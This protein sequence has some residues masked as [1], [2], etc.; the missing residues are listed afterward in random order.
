MGDTSAMP[1][2]LSLAQARAVLGLDR[3]D[4]PS[5]AAA[6]RAAAKASHPDRAGGDVERFRR[7]VEA[8]TVVRAADPGALRPVRPAP[9]PVLRLTP[10]QALR[11]GEV[12]EGGRLLT[13]PAGLRSGDWVRG[14]DRQRLVVLVQPADGL[15]LVGD[16]LYMNWAVDPRRL[17]DGGRIEIQTHAGVRPSWIAPG[18]GTGRVR[19]ANLGLPAR[20][21]RPQGHLFVTLRPCAEAAS[22]AEDLLLRF[23]RVWTPARRAA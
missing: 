22:E 16:D 4:A 14:P 21:S 15:S 7:V 19:L 23:S 3:A 12:H 1:P 11:G 8:W 17:A 6:F 9:A 2:P 5:P 18:G 10:L 20:G 13:V